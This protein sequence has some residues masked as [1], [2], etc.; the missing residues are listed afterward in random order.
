MENWRV[1][2]ISQYSIRS[3]VMHSMEAWIY[4]LYANAYMILGTSY[5]LINFFF[6]EHEYQGAMSP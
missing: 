6:G 3:Y 1:E 5:M 4:Q 2:K